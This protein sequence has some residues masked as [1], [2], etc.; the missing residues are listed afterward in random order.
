MLKKVLS[1]LIVIML[2]QGCSIFSSQRRLGNKVELPKVK[3]HPGDNLEFGYAKWYD[4]Q[5]NPTLLYFQTNSKTDSLWIYDYMFGWKKIDLAMAEKLKGNEY[6][7][8]SLMSII[9]K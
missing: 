5:K 2:I 1:I 9:F 6:P 4:F 3:Y 7:T 8:D